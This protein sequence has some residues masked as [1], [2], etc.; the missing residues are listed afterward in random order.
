MH[1][2]STN[3]EDSKTLRNN[4]VELSIPL[5]IKTQL[6]LTGRSTPEQVDYSVKNRSAG[7]A[8]IF[9]SE[10][11]PLVSHMYQ[12]TNRGPSALNG[13][14]LDIFWP[15]FTDNGANLLYLIDNPYVSDTR[16]VKC[17]VKQNKN[18]NPGS[19]TI[20]NEHVPAVSS[21]SLFKRLRR[22]AEDEL[23]RQAKPLSGGDQT[24]NEFKNA[25][26]QVK[27]AG[28]AIEYT[29]SLS[30][31]TVNCDN[32][33]CTHIECEIKELKEDEYV[34]VEVIGRL[35]VNTLIDKAYFDADISS[36]AIAKVS[37]V[38]FAPKDFDPPS[39]MAIVTTNVNPTGDIEGPRSV[40]WW[41]WLLAILIGI[42]ILLLL[43]LC[44]WKCGF[45]KRNRPPAESARLNKG[46]GEAVTEHFAYSGV[47]TGY[48]PPSVY[49]PDRHGARL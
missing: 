29:G 23:D 22:S 19:L 31:A 25:V 5:E 47:N 41:L 34:L 43:I 37:S 35:W 8:S 21:Q 42:A 9:D 16:K 6:S 7:E 24:R 38:P 11:G 14:T 33:D 49:S 27:A 13:A 45:F 48:A 10:I 2:N 12:V 30:R 4:E 1:A 15:S 28:K 39:Q 40:P 17:R 32:A 3:S 26:K 44:L 36:L 18:I 20:A 46:G